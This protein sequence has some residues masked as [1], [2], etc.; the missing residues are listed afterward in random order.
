MPGTMPGTKLSVVTSESDHN[1]R[2]MAL[3]EFI[4]LW[5]LRVFLTYLPNEESGVRNVM[6]DARILCSAKQTE[7]ELLEN[8]FI[9]DNVKDLDSEKLSFYVV[10]IVKIGDDVEF[11]GHT[12]TPVASVYG[13]TAIVSPVKTAV[14]VKDHTA[15]DPHSTD[16]VY[17]F[18]ADGEVARE[19]VLDEVFYS[20][21]ESVQMMIFHTIRTPSSNADWD[22]VRNA[23]RYGTGPLFVLSKE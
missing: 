23:D 12:F 22:N 20:T 13:K 5:M 18:T 3:R 4:K 9:T 2:M 11:V 19:C 15:G 7:G 17:S 14:F 10:T 6:K 8:P 21:D 16:G 1:T